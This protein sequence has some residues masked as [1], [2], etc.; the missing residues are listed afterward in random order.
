[1]LALITSPGPGATSTKRG[2]PQLEWMAAWTKKLLKWLRV[3][4]KEIA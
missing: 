4:K 3:D 1:M 2:N